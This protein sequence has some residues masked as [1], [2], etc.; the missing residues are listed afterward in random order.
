MCLIA[1]LGCWETAQT[2]F[3]VESESESNYKVKHDR[4]NS[5]RRIIWHRLSYVGEFF[6]MNIPKA[7]QVH[8][9]WR[10]EREKKKSFS[11][12]DHTSLNF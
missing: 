8:K 10:S 11:N 2:E 5:G 7:K 4:T 12:F 6:E 1:L 9:K 3:K